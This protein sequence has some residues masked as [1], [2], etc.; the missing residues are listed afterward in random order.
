VTRS[1]GRTIRAPPIGRLSPSQITGAAPAKSPAW[2][3]ARST[4]LGAGLARGT[5]PVASVGLA[6]GSPASPRRTVSTDT[7]VASAIEARLA[8]SRR[9]PRMLEASSLV[10]LEGRFGPRL[11]GR[12][13]SVPSDS[14]ARVQRLSV[15]S[16]TPNAAQISGWVAAR[17]I[18]RFTAASRRATM[19]PASQQ[20]VTIPQ[21]DTA[22]PSSVSSSAPAG[23]IGTE[24]AGHNGSGCPLRT[25]T[26]PAPSSTPDALTH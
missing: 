10:S 18:M 17:V 6:S 22:P 25:A 5:S 16:S 15:A 24:P 4:S 3:R 21:R 11:S 19:S 23:P 7:P 9:R 2:A 8:F 1:A 14:K 12:S 20:E 26:I 13:P